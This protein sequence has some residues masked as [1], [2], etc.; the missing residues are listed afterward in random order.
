[1]LKGSVLKKIKTLKGKFRTQG[2]GV[3][4]NQN[5]ICIIRGK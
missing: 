4:N 5:A 3:C 2:Y 1:M